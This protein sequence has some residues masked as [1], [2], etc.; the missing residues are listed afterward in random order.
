M[1]TSDLTNGPRRVGNRRPLFFSLKNEFQ[2]KLPGCQV[3]QC[4]ILVES[5]IVDMWL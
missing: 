1:V 3:F 5:V 2:K 4:R